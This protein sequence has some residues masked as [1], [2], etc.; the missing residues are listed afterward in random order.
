MDA[1]Q[2]H[3]TVIVTRPPAPDSRHD[4]RRALCSCGW[5]GPTRDALADAQAD[6]DAHEEEG[7]YDTA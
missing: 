5:Q 1:P 4:R 6:A 2:E 3:M 7:R